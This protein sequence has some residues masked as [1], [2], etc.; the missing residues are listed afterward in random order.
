LTPDVDLYTATVTA[1]EQTKQ[2]LQALRL[3]ESMR[4]D[5]YD[6]YEAPV[7]NEAFKRAVRLV[8]VVGRGLA[9]DTKRDNSTFTIDAQDGQGEAFIGGEND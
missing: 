4:A 7:L 8:N 9:S 5:G 2:P 1:Y 3:M 6:F